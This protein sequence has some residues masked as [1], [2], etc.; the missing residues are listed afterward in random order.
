M[1][2]DRSIIHQTL[3]LIPQQP[4]FRFIDDILEIKDKAITALY[5]FRE[6][7]Y[8]YKGHF[9]GN[10]ITPGVILIETMAQT[11]VVAMGICQLL[12]QGFET[13]RLKA[14]TPLFAFADDIE[15]TGIVSPGEKVIIGGEMVYFRKGT[16]KTKTHISRERG[17]KVC[18]GTLT[19]AGVEFK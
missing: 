17:E 15:F 16:I 7:E 19:G 18:T 3:E 6:D 13:D 4:P 5:R 9:H 12:L 10:P 8:F 14:I 11:G 1:A 2:V